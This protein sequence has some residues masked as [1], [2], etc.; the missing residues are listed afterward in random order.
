MA[1]SY[2]ASK[3][4]SNRAGWSVIFRHPAVVN[5][6]TGKPG[7]RLRFGLG[8]RDDGVADKMVSELNDLLADSRW[9][10]ISARPDAAARFHARVVDIFYGPMDPD[11]TDTRAIRDELLPLPDRDLG[12]RRVL[13]VG[14]TGA[15]KTTV[16]RQLIGSD[17]ETERFPTT[18]TGRTTIADTELILAEVD[19]RAAITFFSLDEITQ[20]LQDC[21][22]QAVLGAYGGEDRGEV[23]RAL[24]RHK[25]ERFR[26]NY[27]LGDGLV[28][29]DGAAA[30]T[31]SLL[32]NTSFAAAA[33]KAEGGM[34]ELG[35]LC[36]EE[37]N[38]VVERLVDRVYAL[39][40][41]AASEIEADLGPATTDEDLRVRDELVEEGLDER[42]RDDEQVHELMDALIDEMRRRFEL[43][44]DIGDLRRNRQGWPISWTWSTD[45]RSEFIRQLRRFTSNSK[46]GFGR[47]LTPLVDGVRVS[48]PFKPAW[49]GGSVPRLVLLDTEGLGHTTES[50]ASVSTK[51]TRL[52]AD[53]DA[54][55]LVDNAEQPMQAAPT[56]LLRSMA[57]T[58]HGA[59]LHIC[60]THFDGVTGDNLPTAAD[61][62]LHVINSCD[63]VLSKI[64]TDLGTF[65]ERPLRARVRDAAYFLADCQRKV[66][67]EADALTVGEFRRL[68]VALQSSGDR[69]TLAETRPVY[70][71]TNLVVAVRDA[72]QGFHDHWDAILGRSSSPDVDKEHWA[73]IKALS[74]R[75]A[76]LNRDEYRHLH[77]VADLQAWLQ[78]Q[79]WLMLQSPVEWTKGEPSVD[80]R[81]ALYDE[82][83]NRLSERM[84][85]LAHERLFSQR[86]NEW[87]DA[88]LRSGR[89]STFERARIIAEN[90]YSSAA[91]V[92]QATPAPHQNEFLHQIIEI[93]RATAAEMEIE[94]R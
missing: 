82:F 74:R 63:G 29:G 16:L 59:K 45:D 57:R 3:T 5:S 42:L 93:V 14:T 58:G 47:L 31:S 92:P 34:P 80:E 6:D 18:A 84:L 35:E 22:L 64:G 69:P 90:I 40:Q 75:F 50:A 4:K 30:K 88:Y 76:V 33:T 13:L 65:A 21:V 36:L 44:G 62:A 52:I 71:R 55:A 54:V 81:Q 79:A 12:Y 26:F 19:Y 48:G 67:E 86:N 91:P 53:A 94:L 78:D 37:T 51:L 72:V 24:L 77:P 61:R 85:D 83:A 41:S 9:W 39:A 20:H 49:Y 73:T 60:F 2:S 46:V 28:G 66:D 43:I 15:G 1:A 70:D 10:S 89:G 56:T 8:T 68:L 27:V 38:E 7:K 25:D 32:A 23:R 87:I 17:P 11:A